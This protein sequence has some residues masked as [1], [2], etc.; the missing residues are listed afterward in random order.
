MNK[1]S[2]M[3]RWTL[4]SQL[5]QICANGE[6]YKK[7]G[8]YICTSS[9]SV[10]FSATC[11]S[12]VIVGLLEQSS[13]SSRSLSPFSRSPLATKPT[14]ITPRRTRSCE[15]E[16][17]W[18]R[19]RKKKR[20][21]M[22][23]LFILKREGKR[24]TQQHSTCCPFEYFAYLDV[25]AFSLLSF[26]VSIW[27]DT[28]FRAHSTWETISCTASSSSVEGYTSECL[29]I[30]WRSYGVRTWGDVASFRWKDKAKSHD[31]KQHTHS[32][33]QVTAFMNN[34]VCIKCKRKT[35]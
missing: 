24:F 20:M 16:L 29:A 13:T 3:P 23:Q 7:T 27:S 6:W 14:L 34:K 32:H 35:S 2:R 19:G 15:S 25:S 4:Q 22:I 18:W 1:E 5:F 31:R 11:W 21:N 33:A 12:R 30:T 17:G 10:S 8:R 28:V 9:C 26:G